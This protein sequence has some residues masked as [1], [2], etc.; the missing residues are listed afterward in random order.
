MTVDGGDAPPTVDV[1]GAALKAVESAAALGVVAQ[2]ELRLVR[3]APATLVFILV[4]WVLAVLSGS[5]AYGPS[6]RLLVN[7]GGNVPALLHLRLYTLLTSALWANN[8]ASYLL[9]TIAVGVVG[10]IVERHWGSVRLMWVS[11][12][13]QCVGLVVGLLSVQ[14]LKKLGSEWATGLAA[15]YAVG[16]WPIVFGV[17][18]AFSATSAPLWRRRIRLGTLATAITLTLYGGLLEDVLRL[19]SAIVG[20]LVGVLV[21]KHA[22]YPR[23]LR[24][25]RRET[26]A[27]VAVLLLASAAAPILVAISNRAAGPLAV[28]RYMFIAPQ[29]DASAL[30]DICSDPVDLLRCNEL[31]RQLRFHGAGPLILS[32]L[33][34]LL[35][36]LL[37]YGLKKGRRFAW[38]GAMVLHTVLAGLGLMFLIQAVAHQR[39]PTQRHEPFIEANSMIGQLL[40]MLVPLLVVVLLLLTRRSFQIPAPHGTYRSLFRLLG[41]SVV[42]LFALY[43]GIGLLLAQQFSPHPSFWALAADFPRRL[44][45]PG[46]LGLV[47]LSF[48]PTTALS[49]FL[50]E[51]TGIALWGIAIYGIIRSFNAS[52][53]DV[54][55]QDAHDARAILEQHGDNALSYLTTWEGNSYW[56]NKSRTV[57][58]AFRVRGGVA[59]TMGDAIGPIAQIGD[60]MRHFAGYCSSRSWTVCFYSATETAREIGEEF[61][62]HSVQVAEETYLPLGHLA[63]TGKKY[64]DIR[65]AGSRAAREGITAE[66]MTFPD[67]P[68]TITDQITAISEEWVATKG[69]PE[70][71]F[72]L[73]GVDELD[74][75]SVRCLIAIDTAGTI[76]GITSW[77]PVYSGGRPIGWTLDYMRRRSTGFKGVMEFLISTAAL[78]FQAEGAQFVSLSGAP[79]A[80]AQ[81]GAASTLLQRLLDR[82]GNSLE[83]VYGFRSLLAFKAKFQPVYRPIYLLY[84]EAASLPRIGNAISRAYLPHLTPRETLKMVRKLRP[85]K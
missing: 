12:L 38:W 80:R 7:V 50:F 35:V 42:V 16:P 44:A 85:V 3:R 66:W 54:T 46:Y 52:R 20:L 56:F 28:L 76:H 2:R 64:Q 68:W 1:A 58:V 24:S 40:P 36:F 55:A 6:P 41:I 84:P 31:T 47:T 8:F 18:M 79:L 15:E 60:A 49:T 63:F 17:L 32:V 67:A 73:G 62:W 83:P 72:T 33:P 71:G 70:M 21:L 77:L 51:W 14:A 30:G 5:A 59:I 81:H 26:R 74:D 9:A 29:I 37:A 43:T 27:L 4:I 10:V 45:P 23:T 39:H 69:L 25:S 13:C 11:L 82:T 57:Y 61:G 48:L 78:Q 75:R 22:P 19:S 34:A 53:V 65:T